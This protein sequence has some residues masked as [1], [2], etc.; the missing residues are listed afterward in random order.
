VS[1]TDTDADADEY[2]NSYTDE[3]TDSDGN[4]YTVSDTDEYSGA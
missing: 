4:L 3:Y 2:V 1:Y